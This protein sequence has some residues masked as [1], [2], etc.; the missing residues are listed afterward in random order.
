M[1]STTDSTANP[2]VLVATPMTSH[3]VVPT[4]TKPKL[5]MS[6]DKCLRPHESSS[7]LERMRRATPSLPRA[8]PPPPKQQTAPQQEVAAGSNVGCPR[9]KK[10]KVA[11]M[12][13]AADPMVI[14][15]APS[16][17]PQPSGEE[18]LASPVTTDT[19]VHNMFDEMSQR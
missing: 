12:A 15:A 18:E 9:A 4:A 2:V 5:P 17:V 3:P 16:F 8:S 6:V 7:W 13:N 14:S 19:D 10:N 1:D 11:T